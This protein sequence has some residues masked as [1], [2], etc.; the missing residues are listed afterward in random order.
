LTHTKTTS[1]ENWRE[2]E[3]A[4]GENE[5]ETRE[6]FEREGV[7]LPKRKKEGKSKTT[8]EKR[9]LLFFLFLPFLVLTFFRFP[10]FP[11]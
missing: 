5:R 4:N 8:R 6:T 10:T 2:N 3:R 9:Q 1:R 11:L 7:F